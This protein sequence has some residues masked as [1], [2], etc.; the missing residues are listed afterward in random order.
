MSIVV[1]IDGEYNG[2]VVKIS[3]LYLTQETKERLL[4]IELSTDYVWED[5]IRLLL[6]KC[7]Y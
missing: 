6:D 1:P 7:G 3:H 2:E 4:Q 5:R